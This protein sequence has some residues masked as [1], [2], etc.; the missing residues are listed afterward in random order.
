MTTKVRPTCKKHGIDFVDA[1]MLWNDPDLL[2]IRARSD[3]E[4]GSLSNLTL[5]YCGTAGLGQ[6]TRS[7]SF[8]RRTIRLK[9]PKNLTPIGFPSRRSVKSDRLLDSGHRSHWLQTLVSRHHL[10]E[11]RYSAHF[12]AS[13]SPNRG[14]TLCKLRISTISLI[15]ATKT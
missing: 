13:C 8:N 15:R 3:D 10:Q 14:R 11:W 7:L 2:E 4:P 9:R 12:C 6:I 1:Q 5:I